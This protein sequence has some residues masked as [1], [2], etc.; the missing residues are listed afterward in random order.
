MKNR[1]LFE[2]KTIID[3]LSQH[4]ITDIDLAF[5]IIETQDAIESAIQTVQKVIEN[6]VKWTEIDKEIIT[7]QQKLGGLINNPTTPENEKREAIDAFNNAYN[8]DQFKGF[9]ERNKMAD[10]I[11]N[12]EFKKE[13]PELSKDKIKTI[14]D[15]NFT[16]QKIRVLNLIMKK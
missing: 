10:E 6:T 9:S 14:K 8:E 5:E 4:V 11:L 13:L 15:L 16:P 12:N 1:D 2:L 7:E 3:E